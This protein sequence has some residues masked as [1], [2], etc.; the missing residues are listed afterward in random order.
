[1][2]YG[3]AVEAAGSFLGVYFEILGQLQNVETIAAGRGV[4]A[5]RRLSRVYGGGRWRKRKGTARVQLK[6]GD[7]REAEI[8]WYESTGVGR[9]EYKIKRFLD[10]PGSR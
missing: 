2:R 6:S 1:M 3:S 4:H 7:V 8:H 9:V 5:R 10:R